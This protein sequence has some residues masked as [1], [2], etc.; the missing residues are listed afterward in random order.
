MA[1]KLLYLKV[2]ILEP[3]HVKKIVDFGKNFKIFFTKYSQWGTDLE[4]K[5]HLK[6]TDFL[7][8]LNSKG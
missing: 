7:M 2:Y 1:K 5:K 8:G 6:K 3:V 4:F